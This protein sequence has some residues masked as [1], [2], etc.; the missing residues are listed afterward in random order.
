MKQR[1][2]L[3][4]A[5]DILREQGIEIVWDDN[6]GLQDFLTY[7]DQHY[8]TKCENGTFPHESFFYTDILQIFQ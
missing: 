6:L 4:Q 1:V 8:K 5:V 7:F 2:T 3:R